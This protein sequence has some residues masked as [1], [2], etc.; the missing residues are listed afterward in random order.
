MIK[1]V[2]D[3]SNKKYKKFPIYDRGKIYVYHT[4]GLFFDGFNTRILELDGKYITINL[5]DNDNID[6]YD[7]FEDACEGE[8]VY[9]LSNE[10]ELSRF[11]RGV[12]SF[13]KVEA[14]EIIKLN[15]Y[16]VS[17]DDVD[18]KKIYAYAKDGEV[19]KLQIGHGGIVNGFACLNSSAGNY[20]SISKY[21]DYTDIY[22]LIKAHLLY[23]PVYQFDTQ[24]EFLKWALEQTI[25]KK[26]LIK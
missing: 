8:E 18:T 13:P 6:T 12:R 1:K 10:A 17:V 2:V 9:I 22:I 4:K 3:K 26:V 7:T 14:E 23:N 20:S 5:A 11:I 16:E 24:E 15:T 25:G 21:T 19:Y